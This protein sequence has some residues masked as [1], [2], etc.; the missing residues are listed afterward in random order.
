MTAVVR[1]TGGRYHVE[2]RASFLNWLA[3]EQNIS[4]LVPPTFGE[5]SQKCSVI[6]TFLC[7]LHRHACSA[8]SLVHNLS[9]SQVVVALNSVRHGLIKFASPRRIFAKKTSFRSGKL[10]GTEFLCPT[11]RF[12]PIRPAGEYSGTCNSR[13]SGRQ[14]GYI[15]PTCGPIYAYSVL[16]YVHPANMRANICIS[17]SRAG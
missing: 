5:P 10:F 13:V 14:S 2:A 7:D 1:A 6:D 15:W 3:S 17:G 12:A 8:N 16:I 9:V 11:I 4:S